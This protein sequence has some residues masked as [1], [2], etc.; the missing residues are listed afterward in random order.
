MGDG[1]GVAVFVAV[2]VGDGVDVDVDVALA[3]ALGVRVGEDV[4]FGVG[5]LVGVEVPSRITMGFIEEAL[6]R[7]EGPEGIDGVSPSCRK[8]KRSSKTARNQ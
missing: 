3:V 7:D 6:S 5:S 8:M 4:G 2:L 1:V